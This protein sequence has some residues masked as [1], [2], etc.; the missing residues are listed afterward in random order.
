MNPIV[1]VEEGQDVMVCINLMSSGSNLGYTL[2]VDLDVTESAK[3]GIY[4]STF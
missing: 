3:A 1:T 2:T 4:I